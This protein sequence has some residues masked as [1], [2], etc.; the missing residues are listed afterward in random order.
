MA[1]LMLLT[2]SYF[3]SCPWCS[4]EFDDHP[5][6]WAGYEQ[7]LGMLAVLFCIHPFMFS[8]VFVRLFI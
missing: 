1:S 6:D 4:H 2:Q 5:A 8:F 7:D 3:A